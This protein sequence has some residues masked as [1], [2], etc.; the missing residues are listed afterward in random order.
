[1]AFWS[2]FDRRMMARAIEIAGSGGGYT[3]ANPRVGAVVCVDERIVAE[4]FHERYGGLHAE[5]NAIA[6]A[7]RRGVDLRDAVMYVTLEPCCHYGK[8]GPCTEAIVEAGFR[9]VVVGASDPNPVVNG[10]GLN[11]LRQA[12]IRVENGLLDG[13]CRAIN[14]AFNTFHEKGRPYVLL[15]WAQSADGFIDALRAPLTPAPWLT[16]NYGRLL[17]HRWRSECMAILVGANTVLRDDPRLSVRA[18]VGP[19]PLRVVLDRDLSIPLSARILDGS[20]PTLLFTSD[21]LVDSPAWGMRA[22]IPRLELAP[23]GAGRE[24][25]ECL[26]LELYRRGVNSLLVEGGAKTIQMFTTS[27]LWD[28]ARIFIAP[29]CLGDGVKAPAMPGQAVSHYC[30]PSFTLLQVENPHSAGLTPLQNG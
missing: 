2:E 10:R 13:E 27:N 21:T 22:R 6:E 20:Q 14:P 25:P 17:V 7:K 11:A 3:R 1:M 29:A 30:A 24:W 8:T 26:L 18:W 4:G 19:Q 12:G 9:R 5:R 15:K 23:L 28:E 16:G